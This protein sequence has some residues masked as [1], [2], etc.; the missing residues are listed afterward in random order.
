LRLSRFIYLARPCSPE[1]FVIIAVFI[2][3]VVEA[4]VELLAWNA[5]ALL[6]PSA[7]IYE[8]AAL[9]AEWPIRVILPWSFF[10]AVWTFYCT[11]HG[12]LA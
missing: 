11:R 8:A 7:K 6:R 2:I 4:I 5:I 9:R 12:S 1:S 3:L 10:P